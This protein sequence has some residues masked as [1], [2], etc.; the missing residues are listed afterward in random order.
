MY[1]TTAQDHQSI[2]IRAARPEDRDAL[3]RVAQRD[4]RAVPGGEVLLALVDGEP[5]AAISLSSGE[6]VADPFH[7]TADLVRMLELHRLELRRNGGTRN[8]PLPAVPA[9]GSARSATC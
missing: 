4:T 9:P 2:T 5:R 6:A 1:H 7:P 3:R 8:L